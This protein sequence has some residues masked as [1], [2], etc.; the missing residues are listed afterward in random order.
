M[1]D[2]TPLQRYKM[3][4]PRGTSTVVV[5]EW[6][7][8]VAIWRRFKLLLELK[9]RC[10]SGQFSAALKESTEKAMTRDCIDLVRIDGWYG[11]A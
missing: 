11:E 5:G 9:D 4:P 2:D 3:R 8:R 10:A 6:V 1:H 7:A